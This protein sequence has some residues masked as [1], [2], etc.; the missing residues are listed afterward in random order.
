MKKES[1]GKCNGDIPRGGKEP[2]GPKQSSGATKYAR[3]TTG[4][5]VE[6]LKGMPTTH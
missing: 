5:K 2:S 1:S 6:N 4:S 3:M